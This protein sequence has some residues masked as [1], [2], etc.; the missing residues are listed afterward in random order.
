MTKQHDT[1]AIRL[2]VIINKLNSGVRFCINDLVEEFNVSKRT[3]QRDMN[4][5]L[6]YLPLKKEN[7]YYFL[8]E[9]CLGK[10]NFN[11][12]KNFATLSGIRD[13]YP[14]L[15]DEFIVDLLNSKLDQNYIIKGYDYED[16]KSK[17]K[18]FHLISSAIATSHN[19]KFRYKNKARTVAPYK[20]VNTDG[21]W[22][23]E[24]VK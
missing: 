19:I 18:E 11:D 16:L 17:S 2:T 22:Y 13:L 8:E 15:N 10:L 24:T 4:Q 9:Y 7:G 14:S 5:R 20:L 1:I 6:S 12:I 21:I 23:L 3:V